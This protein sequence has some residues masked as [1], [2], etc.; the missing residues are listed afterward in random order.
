MRQLMWRRSE[1][2]DPDA[3]GCCNIGKPPGQLQPT[4]LNN[5]SAGKVKTISGELPQDYI[6]IPIRLSSPGAQGP[7]PDLL[8]AHPWIH[9][10]LAKT[11]PK[12]SQEPG[13]AHLHRSNMT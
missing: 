12:L 2:S 13:Y 11:P 5:N 6:Y 10:R 8:V 3:S 7:P 1:I 4:A 9:G